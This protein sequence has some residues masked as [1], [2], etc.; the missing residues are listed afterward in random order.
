M[1]FFNFLSESYYFFSNLN[2]IFFIVG[3]TKCLHSHMKILQVYYNL[4]WNSDLPFHKKI[5]KLIQ[6]RYKIS[7]WRSLMNGNCWT[8]WVLLDTFRSAFLSP[9]LFLWKPLNSYLLRLH[10]AYLICMTHVLENI[11]R[12]LNFRFH[13]TPRLD[14]WDNKSPKF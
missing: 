4:Q 13:S 10:P 14:L 1:V 6:V 7:N 12:F 3:Q 2:P 11:I 8:I 9:C 5:W